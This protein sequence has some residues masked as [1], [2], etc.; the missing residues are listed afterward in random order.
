[1]TI[2]DFLP[3]HLHPLHHPPLPLRHS[4]QLH[5]YKFDYFLYSISPKKEAVLCLIAF[6]VQKEKKKKKKNA[7]KWGTKF[8]F[9][10]LVIENIFFYEMK[11]CLKI[12]KEMNEG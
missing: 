12:A 4:P 6:G 10:T 11:D 3:H 1:M 9:D 7:T 8:F 2:K 5:Y